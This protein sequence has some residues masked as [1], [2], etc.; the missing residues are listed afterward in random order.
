MKFLPARV[1]FVPMKWI[2]EVENVEIVI[3]QKFGG[4]QSGEK[5]KIISEWRMQ[6]SDGFFFASIALSLLIGGFL[7]IL[8][9]WKCRNDRIIPISADIITIKIKQSENH[10]GIRNME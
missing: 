6:R 5:W 9:K 3:I 4:C 1:V 2:N 8:T 10:F 7:L